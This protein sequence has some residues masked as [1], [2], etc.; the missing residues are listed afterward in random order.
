MDENLSLE[1][2][3]LNAGE[4]IDNPNSAEYR[5]SRLEAIVEQIG[6][7]VIATTETVERL[8]ERVDALAIQ[9]QH[10]ANQVQQQGYQVFALSDA[11]ETLVE[12]QSDS[13]SQLNE[14]TEALHNFIIAI[15]TANQNKS[16]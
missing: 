9:V 8:G 10:Q 16:L 4:P 3:N 6:E 13:K 1:P 7:A 5:F 14:L 12:N 2:E 11:L 15:K